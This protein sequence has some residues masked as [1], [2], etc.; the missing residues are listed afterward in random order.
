MDIS[1][2]LDQSLWNY[3]EP[4]LLE[5][6]SSQRAMELASHVAL[7]GGG[8]VHK[9]P[10]VGAVLVDKEHRFLGA[11]AHLAFGQEHAEINLIEKIHER[12]LEALLQ[13]GILYST[14][15]PCFHKGKTQPCVNALE[16]IPIQKLV[17]GNIDPNP[18][19]SGKGIAYLS[20][21]GI[22]CEQSPDFQKMSAHLL[23]VFEWCLSSKRP[24]IALKAALS[25]NGMSSFPNTERQAI[26][27]PRA[28]DYAHWLRR[29]YEAILV[30]SKTLILDNPR[31]DVRHS[32]L[33]GPSP[34]RIAFDPK[35]KALLSRPLEEHRLIQDHPGKTMWAC[36]S[37]FWES[38][39]GKELRT[40]LDRRGVQTLSLQVDRPIESLLQD[41]EEKDC[42]SLLVEGG[43]FVW[44][45]FLNKELFNKLYLFLAPQILSGD[46][47][48][49]TSFLKDQRKIDLEKMKLSLLE[50]D[51]L[52]E[53]YK[54]G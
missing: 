45:S 24:F 6:I 1:H 30:G 52:L 4:E 23:E 51:L 7:K 49:F 31:L 37:S 11:A 43:P 47:L 48:N 22:R 21:K 18:E 38:L 14:L 42:A 53:A 5:K 3:R 36:Y 20:S 27:S 35:G 46:A 16:K 17:Y 9:N 33:S 15:E 44:G 19:V 39:E 26:T 12:K 40:N 32:K 2:P 41:L 10:L 50:K 13:G 25:L 28:L 29:T 34:L 8:R 54:K